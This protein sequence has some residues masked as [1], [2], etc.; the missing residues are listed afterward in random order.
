[1]SEKRLDDTIEQLRA[2]RAFAS[3]AIDGKY[4][5]QEQHGFLTFAVMHACQASVLGDTQLHRYGFSIH[6]YKHALIKATEAVMNGTPIAEAMTKVGEYTSPT[7][8]D[9]NYFGK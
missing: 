9:W 1:M 6:D 3:M 2:A 7:P 8:I 5:T 4:T